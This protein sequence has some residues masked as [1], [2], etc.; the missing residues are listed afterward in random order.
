MEVICSFHSPPF[1]FSSN[2]RYVHG[3]GRTKSDK[4]TNNELGPPARP[5][6]RTKRQVLALLGVVP[7]F[8]NMWRTRIGNYGDWQRNK[9]RSFSG[10]LLAKTKCSILQKRLPA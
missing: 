4:S 1:D 9:G 2:I 5:P 3:E 8:E 6:A 7:N 10:I